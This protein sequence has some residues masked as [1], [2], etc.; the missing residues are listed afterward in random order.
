M[1]RNLRLPSLEQQDLLDGLEVRLLE[2]EEMERAQD[3]LS[4]H[5]YLG[6]LHAVGERLF[7]VAQVGERWLALLG[8][9][10]AAKHLRPRDE[11][12]GWTPEQRRRRLTLM[13]N[14]A[15]FLILPDIECP[16]LASRTLRLC[17]DRLSADWERRYG[18]PILAVETFVDPQ[19]FFGTTYT[20]AGWTELGA[21]AGY[22]RGGRDYYV[23]HDQPK[24]LFMREL[25]RRARRTLQAEHLPPAL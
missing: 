9:H 20:C 8:W 18:H 15:R 7:Y 6:A 4:Q 21:T 14:N 23:A 1:K 16:N 10:A 22:G 12:I 5:H 19:R 24:R 17:L 13:A 2:P 25:R 3:L 11:W